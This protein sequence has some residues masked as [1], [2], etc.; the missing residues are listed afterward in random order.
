MAW[1]KEHRMFMETLKLPIS[2]TWSQELVDDGAGGTDFYIRV[3]PH[4]N[5]GGK[6]N[7]P[8]LVVDK[9]GGA[10]PSLRAA[11]GYNAYVAQFKEQLKAKTLKKVKE[12][13]K[14]DIKDGLRELNRAQKQQGA[15]KTTT[16]GVNHTMALETQRIA[17]EDEELKA[18]MR[19]EE[20]EARRE[21]AAATKKMMEEASPEERQQM[22]ELLHG[23]RGGYSSILKVLKE[24]KSYDEDEEY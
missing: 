21:T 6:A 23:A 2:I 24:T 10:A 1:L 13:A 15:T 4:I 20:E 5:L 11:T 19:R 18:R 8:R 16:V 12:H 3:T 7:T 14:E 9:L 17:R 22:E